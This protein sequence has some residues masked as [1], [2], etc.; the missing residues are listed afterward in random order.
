MA[1][2]L[3]VEKDPSYLHQGGGSG[4]KSYYLA[5]LKPLGTGSTEHVNKFSCNFGDYLMLRRDKTKYIY[6]SEF[7]IE[8]NGKNK[9]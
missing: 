8:V 2:T 5:T 3:I 6:N 7:T 1:F 9:P 4:Q